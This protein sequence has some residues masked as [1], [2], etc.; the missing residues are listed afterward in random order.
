M[1][2]LHTAIKWCVR[3]GGN[4]DAIWRVTAL[5]RSHAQAEEAKAI[6]IAFI[7][8]MKMLNYSRLSR[9]PASGRSVTGESANDLA[10]IVLSS[11]DSALRVRGLDEWI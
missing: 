1:E 8:C 5:L 6:V 10:V 2:A 3:F 11:L 9:E 4:Y 7:A